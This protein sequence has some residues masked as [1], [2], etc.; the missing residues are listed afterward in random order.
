MRNL[1]ILISIGILTCNNTWAQASD[2]Y[3][4]KTVR[5]GF[6]I[7][8]NE[9]NRQ[10]KLPSFPSLEKDIIKVTDEGI[11][12]KNEMEKETPPSPRP[13][14]VVKLPDFNNKPMRDEVVALIPAGDAIDEKVQQEIRQASVY[15]AD[16]GLGDELPHEKAY[17]KRLKAYENDLKTM[18]KKGKMPDN[19]QLKDDLAKMDSNDSFSVE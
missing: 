2:A 7:P 3:V 19:Q 14:R 18:A 16:D 8:E 13:N 17:Q 12:I 10:E 1:F 9:F 5:P 6:F 4:R 11:M 15:T